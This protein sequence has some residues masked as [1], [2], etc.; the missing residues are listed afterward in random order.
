MAPHLTNLGRLHAAVMENPYKTKSEHAKALGISPKTVGVLWKQLREERE[1]V[2]ARQ[3]SAKKAM[4][5]S[6]VD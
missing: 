5:P 4:E 1:Q 6:H 3:K 2:L